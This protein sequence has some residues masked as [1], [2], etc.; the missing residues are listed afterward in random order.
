MGCEAA[1]CAGPATGTLPAGPPATTLIAPLPPDPP[2]L[3]RDLCQK[4]W[5]TAGPRAG[6]TTG[7]PGP[8]R[9]WAK[10]GHH[11][12]PSQGAA[13]REDERSDPGCHRRVKTPKENRY[14][15]WGCESFYLQK[16]F[17]TLIKTRELT[18]PEMGFCGL[19][20]SLKRCTKKKKNKK[21]NEATKKAK[22]SRL[23][24]DRGSP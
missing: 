3:E 15:G 10:P 16:S 13:G 17:R 18:V 23:Q 7:L 11:Q 21:K 5:E 8:G 12:T 22:I 4:P 2:E 9:A 6:L 20:S 1:G 19:C 24:V 14:D